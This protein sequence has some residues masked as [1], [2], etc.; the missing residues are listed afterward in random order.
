ML[1]IDQGEELFLAEAQAEAQPFLVLLRDLLIDEAPAVV[2]VFTI[3]SDNYERL[4]VAKELDGIR[5]QTLSLPPVPKGAYAEVIKGPARRLEGTSRALKIEDR[6]VD[7]LLSDI[8][9]GGATDALPLLAF[10]LE[11]LYVEYHASGELKLSDY[12]EL[13]RIKGSIEAAV[14][15]GFKTADADPSIPRDRAARLALLRQSFI[16]WL[17]G[18]DTETGAPRRRVARLSEIPTDARPLIQ[19]FVDQRLLATDVAKDTGEAT[20]EP[21]HEALLR[22][23]GLLQGWL[24]EDAGLLSVI[25]GVKRASRDW[26]ANGKAGA[27]LTH[28]TGRLDAAERLRERPD[29]AANLDQTD[30][31]YIAACRRKETADLESERAATRNRQ[32]ML[33]MVIFLLVGV[34][35]G[36][37]AWLNQGYLNERYTW[38]AV[39]RPYMMNSVR[40]YVLAAAAE[41]ALKP[42]QTF[43][44]CARDC[45][46][47]LVIP[48]G[49]FIMGSPDNEADRSSDEGPL[50]GVTIAKPFAIS[51][52]PV[53]FARVG[54][55]R[56]GRR[57]PQRD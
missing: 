47:M 54:R 29:L 37:L 38:F 34:T 1:S 2:A 13:G 39:A 16:P 15:E 18:I 45:P 43:R 35:G 21:A 42:G 52:S 48:S 20:I 23:W 51:T 24:T 49:S 26:A 56:G 41:R 27:W 31:D 40:P 7:E 3:R 36:L 50:R 6:L 53:T 17:A 57:L 28:T 55:L 46:E 22:Q 25:D 12:N 19:H 11:R 14:E 4:Q 8:E 5:Q 32:R 10:T 30:R 33:A 44:E 9:A